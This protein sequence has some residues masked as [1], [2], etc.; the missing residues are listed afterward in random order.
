MAIDFDNIH[1]I[2]GMSANEVEAAIRNGAKLNEVINKEAEKRQDEDN[3]IKEEFYNEINKE[4]AILQGNIDAEVQA[5]TAKDTEL[6][7]AINSKADKQTVD[8]GFAGG[9]GAYVQDS[10]GAAV[11]AGAVAFT[12]GAVGASAGAGQ[13]GAVGAEALADTGGAVG[14]RAKAMNGGAVGNVAIT[15]DGFAGGS[16]AQAVDSSGA[17]IDAIQLGTGTNTNSKTLQ[18]Y[19]YQLMDAEGNIP[20]ERMAKEVEAREAKDAELQ[21]SIN[22]RVEFIQA[23]ENELDELFVV[24]EG[25][26]KVL[27]R[28]RPEDGSIIV[29]KTWRDYYIIARGQQTDNMV[30]KTVQIK[31]SFY[32]IYERLGVKDWRGIVGQPS[33]T[34]ITWSEWTKY[35]TQS[36]FDSEIEIIKESID[37]DMKSQFY[38]YKYYDGREVTD[39]SADFELVEGTQSVRCTNLSKSGAITVP[40]KI[41]DTIVTGIADNAFE[42]SLCY[43]VIIPNTITSIGASAFKNATNLME[44][45]IPDSVTSI[46]E[47]CFEGCSSLK[48]VYLSDSL[49]SL[50]AYTFKDCLALSTLYIGES[51]SSIDESIFTGG[52]NNGL[53]FYT[54]DGC[55]ADNFAQKRG[56]KTRYLVTGVSQK[57]LDKKVEFRAIYQNELDDFVTLAN[58]VLKVIGE[59]RSED[60][61]ITVDPYWKDYYVIVQGTQ[62]GNGRYRVSNFMTRVD[63]IYVRTGVIDIL[64]ETKTWSEWEKYVT[65]S[66]LDAEAQTRTKADER[67]KYYGDKDI[68]PSPEEYFTVNETGD[69]ITGLKETGLQQT[70][71]VIPYKINGKL[72]TRLVY[73]TDESGAA[74][75]TP[76]T[77]CTNLVNVIMPNSITYM[78]EDAFRGCTSLK[79][80][81]LSNSLTEIGY[82]VFSRCTSLDN[83]IIPNSVTTIDTF[84]FSGCTSLKSITIPDS[85]KTIRNAAFDG[86][87]SLENIVIPNGITYIG[88]SVFENCT[89]LKSI[90]IPK[91]V[92]SIDTTYAFKGCT[93][94]TIYCEQGSYAETYA[95]E[96]DIPV[97]YTDIKAET[98]DNKQ[99]KVIISE[100]ADTETAL[101]Y[102]LSIMHNQELRTKSTLANGITFLIPNDVYPD[103]YVTSL[104]FSTG[105]TAPQIG[106]SATGILNWVGTDCTIIDGK[107]IFAPKIN[108]HY[109]IVIYFNGFQFVGLVNGFIPAT[110]VNSGTVEEATEATS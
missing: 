86:C 48:T 19:D 35:I 98:L 75:G 64:M 44:I 110:I 87:T 89:L 28:E 7:T 51:V 66:E 67:L 73:K 40:Y 88:E 26:Y 60:G 8:G 109:D 3:K 50:P 62:I 18:V 56:F 107:S 52:T 37:S 92:T 16:Y 45:N 91:S 80:V 99:D 78:V 24:G 25:I 96:Q 29:D 77:E 69:G 30:I 104:S 54:I 47:S 53:C 34:R 105:G 57:D 12:G 70:D 85:V 13:G 23:Y 61:Y 79:S 43:E 41:G 22:K 82:N 90:Y 97:V 94:L 11:G 108:T 76:F 59:T 63:G 49:T 5:R 81:K 36:E 21:E 55:V 74:C 38:G 33:G 32:G 20:I 68:V 71:I 72:I 93:N 15:G 95:K 17:G 58:V 102:D 10:T 14:L 1:K 42:N 101:T 9:E 100:L 4:K 31:V 103:D 106:Y 2:D 65:K 39:D 6:Q 46:G 84:A 27:G 83:V